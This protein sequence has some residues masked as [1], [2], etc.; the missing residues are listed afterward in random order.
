[1][2]ASAASVGATSTID[3]ATPYRPPAT[4]EPII[5]S[6]TRVSYSYGVP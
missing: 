1:M 2:P 6:G 4:R 5:A 3:V